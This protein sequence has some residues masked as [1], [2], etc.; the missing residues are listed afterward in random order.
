MKIYLGFTVAGSRSSIEAA[1]KILNVLQS[2]GHEVLT[3][4]LVSDEAWVA[5]RSVAPQKIFARDMNWLAQC[6]LFVAEVTGSSSMNSLAWK[7]K[8]ETKR[9]CSFRHGRIESAS[10]QITL[11]IFRVRLLPIFRGKVLAACDGA[12]GENAPAWTSKRS[13]IVA[14]TGRFQRGHMPPNH[15]LQF[16]KMGVRCQHAVWV[17]VSGDQKRNPALCVS[18]EKQDGLFGC[19]SKE[20]ASFKTQTER[21]LAGPGEILVLGDVN[22]DIIARVKSFPEPGEE[23]LAQCL[24]LHCGGVG[25]NYA[26]ALRQWSISPRLVACIG[27]DDFAAF[28][29]RTLANHGVDVSNVQRTFAALTGLLYI[30]VTPNGQRTFF[31]S[32]GANRF[33]R[34][35]PSAC[36]M[37]NRAM[38]VSLMGYNFFDPGPEATAKQL[39]KAVHAHGGWVSLDIGMASSEQIPNKILQIVKQVDLLFVSSEEATVLTGIATRGNPSTTSRKLEPVMWS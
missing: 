26:L 13:G 2:L 39:Q 17:R 1:K 31:G 8:E 34:R 30:N 9:C 33:L 7:R 3:S 11:R 5:D 38:A 25:A 21:R 15:F 19:R 14:P 18:V 36:R 20:I 10:N 4:H 32:R 16:S 28:L 23:C 24:E 22:V 29:I 27:Q 12:T 6:D 35:M 37:L